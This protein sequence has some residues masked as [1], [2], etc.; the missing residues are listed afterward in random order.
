VA[1]ENVTKKKMTV[2]E[3][4]AAIRNA[5]NE[6]IEKGKDLNHLREAYRVIIASRVRAVRTE[7]N[8]TQEEVSQKINTNVLTYRGYENCKSDIPIVYLIRIAD[9]FDVSMDYLTGRTDINGNTE[10]E[11]VERLNRLEKA[12]KATSET[13]N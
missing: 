13:L 7:A 8:M 1:T 2:A 4:W 5:W 12:L 9:L 11:I 6:G 10:R 3:A